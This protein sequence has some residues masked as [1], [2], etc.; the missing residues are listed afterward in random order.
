[1]FF[2]VQTMQRP[3]VADGQLMYDARPSLTAGR[4]VLLSSICG[5]LWWTNSLLSNGDNVD[6]SFTSGG[7]RRV[8]NYGLFRL[9]EGYAEVTFQAVGGRVQ[10]DCPY[11]H[12]DFGFVCEVL[13]DH[14]CH[15][16]PLLYDPYDRVWT[17][18]RG[19]AWTVVATTL[20]SLCFH[21]PDALLVSGNQ[22]LDSLR[23][24]FLPDAPGPTSNLL[25]SAVWKLYDLSV[26]VYP[27]L[28]LMDEVIP[29]QGTSSVFRWFPND[30]HNFWWSVAAL[31][32]V[33]AVVNALSK[34]WS[35]RA[36]LLKFKSVT[37]VSL[38][39]WRAALETKPGPD[40]VFTL[41]V[42]G[43]VS[44]VQM[45]YTLLFVTF[46]QGSLETALFSLLGYAV[47]GQLAR[48]Q[49][50]N[51]ALSAVLGGIWRWM[52]TG[53]HDMKR[54]LDRIWLQYYGY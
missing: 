11:D 2:G 47:G 33:A 16:K 21:R 53:M 48:Y 54:T 20:L 8:T 3:Y 46:M 31:F 36:F 51:I 7:R 19:L 50:E 10:F 4:F 41:P 26:F 18:H 14:F 30:D 9:E 32:L 35:G 25:S 34:L 29:Y 12:A 49:Y 23:S 22:L 44:I 13:R 1:V 5:A 42:L 27:V 6:S 37:A 39:Y 28:R 45:C 17:M 15:Q 52:E 38:G 43:S 40:V 24:L